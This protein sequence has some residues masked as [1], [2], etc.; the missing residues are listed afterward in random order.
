MARQREE[1]TAVQVKRLR[2]ERDAAHKQARTLLK[3]LLCRSW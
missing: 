3:P 2:L 1:R